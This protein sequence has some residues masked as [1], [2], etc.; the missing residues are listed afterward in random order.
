MRNLVPRSFVLLTCY[1]WEVASASCDKNECPE[2]RSPSDL[3]SA[4]FG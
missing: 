2:S 4:V 3:R 1:S